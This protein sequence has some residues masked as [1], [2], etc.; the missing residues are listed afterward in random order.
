MSKNLLQAEFEK[1]K[2]RIAAEMENSS[3]NTSFDL[4]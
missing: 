2:T 3:L 4:R 1:L